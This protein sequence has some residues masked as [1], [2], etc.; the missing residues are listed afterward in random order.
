[1]TSS[2]LFDPSLLGNTVASKLPDGYVIRPLAVEDYD[3]GK[4]PL[5]ACI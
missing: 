3:K 4:S 2:L 1:M 5:T